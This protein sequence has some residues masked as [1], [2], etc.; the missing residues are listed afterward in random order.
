MRYFYY[1]PKEMNVINFAVSPDH[2]GRSL[3][4]II[5]SYNE[6]FN[7]IKSI[8]DTFLDKVKYFSSND[9]NIE[10]GASQWD[11]M[12]VRVTIQIKILKPLDIDE[13]EKRGF[14]PYPSDFRAY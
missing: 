4:N 13:I 8:S 5:E 3:K 1:M 12:V 11:K 14:S 7:K 10:I 2:Y 9:A 6:L